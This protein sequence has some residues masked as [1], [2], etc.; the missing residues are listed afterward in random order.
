MGK[1]V[2][3]IKS[4][5]YDFLHNNTLKTKFLSLS[6]VSTIYTFFPFLAHCMTL[7]VKIGASLACDFQ[8]SYYYLVVPTTLLYLSRYIVGGAKQ[9][10]SL[11]LRSPLRS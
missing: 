3:Q 4:C 1:I 2:Q 6:G 9:V 11:L 8:C 10:R 7:G 5:G